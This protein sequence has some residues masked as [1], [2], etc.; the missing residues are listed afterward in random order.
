MPLTKLELDGFKSFA[1]KTT[2]HFNSGITGIV[3]PNGSGKSNITEAIRWV[4]GESS[5]KSLRGSNMKDVIFAGSEFRKPATHAEVT[6]TFA[7]K[8]HELNFASDEVTVGRRILQSGDSE[9]FINKQNVRLKDVQALF[10]DSGIS[11]NSLAIISQGRVDQILNSKPEA[12]RVIFEEA[13]GVLHFKKQKEAAQVQLAKTNDNLIRINDL[14]KELEKRI[15][16]LHEQSSLAQ[17]Y[18]FQKAG[19]DKKLKT[20]LA[21]EIQDLN[22]QKSTVQKKADQNQILLS[23]LD[24]EVTESQSAVSAKKSEYQN[25]TAK[26]E[27]LQRDLLEL[28]DKQAKL[29]T[30]LQVTEQSKQYDEA[31]KKEYQDELQVLQDQ[32]KDAEKAIAVI[33]TETQELQQK[34]KAL[35]KTRTEL[36]AQLKDD[37]ETLNKKL[38]DLRND[39]IEILQKQTSNNNQLVY[40]NSELKRTNDDSSYRDNDVVK[41]LE[42][43]S[44]ALEDLRKKGQS[45]T[46][47]RTQQTEEMT[48]LQ[49]KQSNFQ[50]EINELRQKEGITQNALQQTLARYEA[51]ENIQKRHEGYYYGVRNV[52]NNLSQYPGIVGAIGELISFPAELEAAMTTALGGGVQ[53]LVAKTRTSAR[54]AINQLKRSHAG[55]AT[56]LPLDGLRSYNIPSSTVTTLKTFTGF[57]GVASKLVTSTAKIDIT[58]A[59]EYLLGSSIIVDNIDNALQ[60]SRKL[61]RYRVITLDGDVISPGGSMTGGVRNQKNNSPLQT[62]AEINELKQKGA[63]LKKQVAAEKEKLDKL[64]KQNEVNEADLSSLNKELQETQQQLGEAVLSFQNQE[65]EVKRLESASKLF[66]SQKQERDK[67]LVQL[68]KEI[69][70]ATEE[71]TAFVQ[72]IAEQK[73]KIAQ[74]QERINNFTSLNEKVQKQA[75]ELDPQIAVFANKLENSSRQKQ[76][77]EQKLQAGQKQV[78]E[79]ENKLT[80][81]DENSALS[82]NQ[83]TAMQ[84]EIKQMAD[85]K[86]SL[87]EQLTQLSSKLGRFN[88]QINQLDQVA[89]RNY[90]LRKDAADEQENLSVE[91]AKFTGSIDHRLKRLGSDYSLTYEAALAQA[92]GENNA[93][94]RAELQKSVKLHRMSL[95]DIGP[96]NLDAINE[97]ENVKKRYDFLNGQQD[98]LLK[99][100][101]NLEKS[102]SAL[103]NEVSNRFSKTFNSVAASFTALFPL[104]FGG[105]NARL[106]LTEPDHMLTT[107]VEIVA[108]PPGK[109][110]QRLSLLSGGERA[111]TAI[112]LLFAM[113]KVKPVP[114]CV[115]DE[116]EAA[117]DDAN[118]SR[119]AQFLEKYDLKTQFIVITHRRGT[120]EEADQLYGVVMQ[121]SG[122]SQVLS[123]SLKEIKDEVK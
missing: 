115:L 108:Q 68:K 42:T 99:A 43:A 122:V 117:L 18:Q 75:A 4:M 119:F 73:E 84:D 80:A 39:Y 49:Q 1:E 2:I 7:N 67:Q 33:N 78:T 102:M 23:K 48:A 93:E 81:I 47:K 8:N 44:A 26:R 52:L 31:T 34:Q 94:K 104:V 59:I 98:D 9:Y 21:F 76:E 91:L 22:K 40:L 106:V 95:E 58:P 97:Y 109:K 88:A 89:S 24:R 96:V 66:E 70:K 118:V 103:D 50:A 35:K 77:Q 19:L 74:V 30:K 86:N 87:Q 29:N 92:E 107:G 121:E 79:L 17:E 12:R 15:E 3:G 69:T 53:D 112:T 90:D 25:L 114:F 20:L 82:E 123:V 100:R 105:G 62:V 65:K 64:L 36:T 57:I 45:L 16:P 10:L 110:L 6:L 54:D 116:V 83:K 14:V 61:G 55:R 11:Q 101:D 28:T 13:A 37:P 46:A 60:I 51:L 120:M 56:F 38:E 32:I 72:K 27:Q 113:L 63:E 5:A 41:Q 85:K 111:L 71:K